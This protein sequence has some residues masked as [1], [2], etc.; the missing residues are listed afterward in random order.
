[1]V[2]RFLT[3]SLSSVLLHMMVCFDLASLYISCTS[4]ICDHDK[5]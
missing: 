3:C 2:T 5:S 4:G 1:M